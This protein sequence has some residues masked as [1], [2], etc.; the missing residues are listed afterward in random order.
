MRTK[1]AVAL[2]VRK[3]HTRRGLAL[4]TEHEINDVVDDLLNRIKG[5]PESEAVILE[6]DL[7]GPAHAP[8][9][10]RWDIDEPHPFPK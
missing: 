6:P 1:L 9:R 3:Q 5:R 7:A 10:G 8:W 2:T 4:I